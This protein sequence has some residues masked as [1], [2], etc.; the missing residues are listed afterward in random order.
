MREQAQKDLLNQIRE[1]LKLP[2]APERIECFDIST[3]QGDKPVGSMVVFEGAQ[4][5]KNRYRRYAI[6]QVEGQDDFAMMREVL[7]RRFRNMAKK[8][9]SD[10]AP[11]LVVVDGGKG[12]LSV[13]VEALAEMGIEGVALVG[14]A[15]SRLKE[16]E[17]G[18]EKTRTPERLFL[19]GRKNPVLFPPHAPS[20]YLLQRLRD[21]NKKK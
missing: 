7:Q 18:E 20:F 15:K 3:T 4:P 10:A 6:K 8:K 11:D 1:K 5:A 16:K 13:A 17:K 12:Q 21:A 2:R 19:P 14:L 9:E